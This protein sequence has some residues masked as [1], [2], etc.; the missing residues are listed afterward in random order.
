MPGLIVLLLL[1]SAVAST[2]SPDPVQLISVAC[3]AAL[4]AVLFWKP[5]DCRI[6]LLPLLFQWTAVAVKP[7]RSALSGYPLSDFADFGTNLEPAVLLAALGLGGLACGIRWG[8]HVRPKTPSNERQMWPRQSVLSLAI[9]GLLLGHF[10]DYVAIFGSGA[11]QIILAMGSVKYA[12]LF[13]LAY[14]TFSRREGLIWLA[15]VVGV[16]IVLGM[17]GFF[18]EFKVTLLVVT[19]ALLVARRRFSPGGL[20]LMSTLFCLTVVLASFWTAIKVEYRGYVSGG[21]DA[22]IVVSSVSENASY[23]LTR[24]GELEMGDMLAGFEKLLERVTYVDYLSAVMENVPEKVPHQ[25]GRQ[26]G[27]ALWHI[28]TPRLFFPDKPPTPHDTEVTAYYTGLPMLSGATVEN[29]SISIGYLGELYIDFG[30][31]GGVLLTALLGWAYG[32]AFRSIRD[33][34]GLPKFV[35]LGFCMMIALPLATFETALIKLIGG[36]VMS[37]LVA[38]LLQRYAVPWLL[39]RLPASRTSGLATARVSA[40][41]RR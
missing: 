8:S 17:T 26:I 37:I 39:R 31:T 3:L 28:A 27:S 4:L 5:A 29:T 21:T 13:I 1:G 30:W 24:A 32:R 23:L 19:T 9:A 22:Q 25:E 16:E 34:S 18:A 6:L 33:F 40:L 11:R 35:N 14:W 15:A 10:L 20:A 41:P 36:V 12:A 38:T 2:F 7:V